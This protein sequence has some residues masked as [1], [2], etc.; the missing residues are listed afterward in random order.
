MYRASAE[1][2]VAGGAGTS[3]SGDIRI[4]R[5]DAREAELARGVL[6]ACR[7]AESRGVHVVASS[8]PAP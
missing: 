5:N 1:A 8:R 7:M 3:T 2:G 6:R 4:C